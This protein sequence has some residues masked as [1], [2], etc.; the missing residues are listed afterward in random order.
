MLVTVDIGI[1][2]VLITVN[3]VS[4][5]LVKVN[6]VISLVLVTCWLVLTWPADVG[7]GT[8]SDPEK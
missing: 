1:S 6:L 4:S 3:V 2:P 5:G 8:T 7:G